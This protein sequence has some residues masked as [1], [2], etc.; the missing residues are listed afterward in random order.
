ML[1]GNQ[2]PYT[3]EAM[4]EMRLKRKSLMDAT[5]GVQAKRKA[6]LRHVLIEGAAWEQ[7]TSSIIAKVSKKYTKK[8]LGAKAVKQ[9]ERLSECG[10]YL[11]DTESTTYRALAA[12][13]NYLAMDRP[14]CAYATKELCRH[15]SAPT[16]DSV[17]A[18][19]R[20]VRFLVG[21]PRLVWFYPMQDVNNRCDVYVDTDYGGCHAT[22]RSTS[23]GAIM[24]GSHLIKHWSTTQTTVALSSAEAELTGICKGASQGLGLQSLAGDLGL[25]WSLRVATDAAA[26]VGICRRRGL[27]KIRHLATADLWVQDRVKKKDFELLRVPGVSNPSDILTKHVD[28]TILDKHLVALNLVYE[29]GRASSAP[30]I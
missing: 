7:P 8:R 11:N 4:E 3:G 30:S 9:A 1:A 20:L 6:I 24:H 28:R 27:G 17:E 21:R 19:K 29:D 14:D 23:G 5:Y 10:E 12:R 2:D 26:A 15:F 16:K 25:K 22:R 13:A 18:L